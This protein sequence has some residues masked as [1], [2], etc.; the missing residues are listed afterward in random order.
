ML[1]PTGLRLLVLGGRFGS[2][3]GVSGLV[4]AGWGGFVSVFLVLL[5]RS[6]LSSFALFWLL[7]SPLLVPWVVF[8]LVIFVFLDTQF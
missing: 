6:W 4:G 3:G 2:L 7:F 1:A 8:F 5:L